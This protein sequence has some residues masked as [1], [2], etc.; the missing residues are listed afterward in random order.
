MK[1]TVHRSWM[2]ETETKRAVF[3]VLYKEEHWMRTRGARLGGLIPTV[4]ENEGG[5]TI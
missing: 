1:R 2:L 4:R 5:L 3:L